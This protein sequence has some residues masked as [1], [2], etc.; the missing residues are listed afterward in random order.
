MSNLDK[1]YLHNL[2]IDEASAIRVKHR[3]VETAYQDGYENGY[4]DG[5]YQGG[6]EFFDE[7]LNA[8]IGDLS[9]VDENL[10]IEN[11]NTVVDAIQAQGIKDQAYTDNAIEKATILFNTEDA[12]NILNYGGGEIDLAFTQHGNYRLLCI[13]TEPVPDNYLLRWNDTQYSVA[14]VFRDSEKN[15][16]KDTG[17]KLPSPIDVTKQYSGEYSDILLY[18]AKGKPNVDGN[19]EISLGVDLPLASVNLSNETKNDLKKVIKD[20]EE[21]TEEFGSFSA[22][23]DDRISDLKT[24]K[25][26]TAKIGANRCGITLIAHGGFTY[27]YP[28]NTI[29]SLAGAKKYGFK[30]S[31]CDLRI[32]SDEHFVLMHDATVDRTTNGSG[33]V[34]AMTLEQIK[35]LNIDFWDNSMTGEEWAGLTVPTLDEYL[36]ECVHLD[37][38][39]MLE[40]RDFT[41]SQLDSLLSIIRKY[42]LED[43]AIVESFYPETCTYL[44]SKS[45]ICLAPLISFT[46][47]N[48]DYCAEL[49]NAYI[50]I[51]ATTNNPSEELMRYA[52]DR[53]VGVIAWTVNLPDRARDLERLGVQYIITDRLI[54]TNDLSN[55]YVAEFRSVTDNMDGTTDN[56]GFI[57]YEKDFDAVYYKDLFKVYAEIFYTEDKPT[58][59]IGAIPIVLE[60]K[61]NE[62][63]IVDFVGQ[64]LNNV[65]INMKDKAGV[66]YVRNT[67]IMVLKV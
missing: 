27:L 8:K 66:A 42:N 12:I 5:V 35:A 1:D 45:S 61:P 44:R 19:I 48:V 47:D 54:Y 20:V 24:V 6:V 2:F 58:M 33:D 67:R 21:L 4:A 28:E 60:D 15:T 29:I 55:A 56:W 40:A 46:R 38:V 31:E 26:P 64:A 11:G 34:S 52:F 25:L 32:T 9:A 22:E 3:K 13:L 59:Q 63:Q 14:I 43:V 18:I 39:P 50:N 65:Q 16:L 49:G 7:A 51:D 17:W 36:A 41:E 30:I 23:V 53:G 62:W 10:S 37:I 57:L